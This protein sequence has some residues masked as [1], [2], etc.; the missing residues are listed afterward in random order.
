M[1]GDKKIKQEY[2]RGVYDAEGCISATWQKN[3]QPRWRITFEM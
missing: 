1:K 2:L 3:T